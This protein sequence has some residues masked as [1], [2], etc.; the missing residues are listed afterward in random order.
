MKIKDKY[1]AGLIVAVLVVSIWVCA[2]SSV[3]NMQTNMHHEMVGHI[4]HA[5]TLTLA[6]IPIVAFLAFSLYLFF[7][8]LYFISPVD[9]PTFECLYIQQYRPPLE[10][11]IWKLFNPRSPPFL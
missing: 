9:V 6:I 1:I 7:A 8:I 11:Y 4:D 10:K 5:E 2:V 3:L